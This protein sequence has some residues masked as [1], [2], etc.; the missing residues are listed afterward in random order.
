GRTLRVFHGERAGRVLPPRYLPPAERV[1]GRRRSRRWQ[2]ERTQQKRPRIRRS[3]SEVSVSRARVLRRVPGLLRA[4][5][6]V[7]ALPGVPHGSKVRRCTARG[8]DGGARVAAVSDDWRHA[9]AARRSK[10]RWRWRGRVVEG[11]PEASLRRGGG[12]DRGSDADGNRLS[13]QNSGQARRILAGGR[14]PR[15]RVVRARLHA[16]RCYPHSLV[17]LP[18]GRGH[19]LL[20]A[21]GPAGDG[22]AP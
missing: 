9:D 16:R 10:R 7:A 13:D 1:A 8:V 20:R 19:L 18:R 17:V 5:P 3:L 2:G 6:R 11:V 12:G 15:R 21:G 22:P 4:G 14:R